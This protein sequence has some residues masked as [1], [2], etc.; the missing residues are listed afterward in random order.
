[1]P[2]RFGTKFATKFLTNKGRSLPPQFE[3][4]QTPA[5]GRRPDPMADKMPAATLDTDRRQSQRPGRA[6]SP[7]APALLGTRF[8]L[9]R[10]SG[11]VH[12]LEFLAKPFAERLA[13]ALRPEVGHEGRQLGLHFGVVHRLP[14]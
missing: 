5:P 8:I 6:R 11:Q 7:A 1:M 14:R 10:P 2:T 9:P 4:A 12:E 3:N 13:A